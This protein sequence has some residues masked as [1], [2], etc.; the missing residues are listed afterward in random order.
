MAN[1]EQ[2]YAGV[3]PFVSVFDEDKSQELAL[4]RQ[5]S[6]QALDLA[7]DMREENKK[8]RNDVEDLK[9]RARDTGKRVPKDITCV[10]SS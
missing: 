10:F 3:E 9:E 6:E 5:K 1:L 8:L 4:T 2:M 7:L